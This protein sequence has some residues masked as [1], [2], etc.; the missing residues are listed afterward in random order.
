MSFV[1]PFLCQYLCHSVSVAQIGPGT[2]RQLQAPDL[3]VTGFTI[4]QRMFLC[5]GSYDEVLMWRSGIV[6]LV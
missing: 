2:S 3:V 5:V 1:F 6:S 4:Q